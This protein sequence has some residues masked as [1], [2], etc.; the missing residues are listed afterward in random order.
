MD[1]LAIILPTS[2]TMIVLGFSLLWVLHAVGHYRQ[3][4][5]GGAVSTT[6]VVT[7][8]VLVLLGLLGMLGSLGPFGCLIWLTGPVVLVIAA[9]RYFTTQRDRLLWGLAAAAERRIPLAASARSLAITGGRGP[10]GSASTLA[11]MLEAGVPLPEALRRTGQLRNDTSRALVGVGHLCGA[12]AGGLRDAATSDLARYPLVQTIVG[13]LFY[14]FV[15]VVSAVFIATFIMWKIVPAFAKI[16]EDFGADLPTLTKFVM[17]TAHWFVQ[18]GAPIFGVFVSLLILLFVYICLR[19]IGW[20]RFELPGSGLI[21]RLPHNAVLLR[22]L[23]LAAESGTPLIVVLGNLADSF[24][25]QSVRR[26]LQRATVSISRGDN[27]R[28]ALL[29]TG[30]LRAVDISLL[31][32]AE[33]AGN[34]PWVLRELADA[35]MRHWV[36]RVRATLD[37]VTPIVILILGIF[38]CFFVVGLFIPLVKLIETLS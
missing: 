38:G 18:F 1:D 8:W 29:E 34:L 11:P 7:G 26:R 12:T 15:V 13:R 6:F 36:Y 27:W 2:M 14:L 28:A 10:S 17:A 31:E 35:A 3:F 23:A 32:A 4:E 19:Y 25:R 22:C 24:P 9:T 37:V 20:I 5:R 33:R 16:F 30:L 21:L